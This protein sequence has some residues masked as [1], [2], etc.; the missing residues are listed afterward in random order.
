MWH[1]PLVSSLIVGEVL[2][3][4]FRLGALEEKKSSICPQLRQMTPNTLLQNCM[5][6]ILH[7]QQ[8]LGFSKTLPCFKSSFSLHQILSKKTSTLSNTKWLESQ[9]LG[10]ISHPLDSENEYGNGSGEW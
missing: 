2:C 3:N 1:T 6:S 8:K 7:F 9:T 4:I 5:T 10:Q